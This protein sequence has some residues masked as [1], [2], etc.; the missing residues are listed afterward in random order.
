MAYVLKFEN[1]LVTSIRCSSAM[2]SMI[3]CEATRAYSSPGRRSDVTNEEIKE[4]SLT[5]ILSENGFALLCAANLESPV[6]EGLRIDAQ[7]TPEV[8][9]LTPRTFGVQGRHIK[10]IRV[11]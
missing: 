3:S 10:V 11:Q 8:N 7:V 2:A 5:I 6:E 1:Q 9:R 4:L